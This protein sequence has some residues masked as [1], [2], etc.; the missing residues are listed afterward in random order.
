MYKKKPTRPQL[1]KELYSTEEIP[2]KRKSIGY[3]NP[4]YI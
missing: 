2:G 3:F 1:Y 4:E